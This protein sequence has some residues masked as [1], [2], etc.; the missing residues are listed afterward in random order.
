MATND[1]LIAQAIDR[2]GLD[3]FGDDSFR[4]SLEMFVRSLRTEAR[5]TEASG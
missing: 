5:L 4:E 1:D 2:T 3:H